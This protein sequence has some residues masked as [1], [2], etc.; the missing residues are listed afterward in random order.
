LPFAIDEE[1]GFF[2]DMDAF[3]FVGKGR[4][5]WTSDIDSEVGV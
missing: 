5:I 3:T 4:L 1:V 2:S